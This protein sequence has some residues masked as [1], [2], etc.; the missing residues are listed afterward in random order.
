MFINHRGSDVK[1]TF[2]TRLY[3][4][5]HSSGL[6]AFFDK[7][8][9]QVGYE[10]LSQI[11]AAIKVA[12]VHIAIFSPNYAAS[13]WCLNELVDMKNSGAKII[14][15]FYNVKPSMVRWT[16]KDAVGTYAE[17]L[18]NH[19]EKQRYDRRIIQ[20]WRE[21]LSHAASLS[22]LELEE[23]HG[24]EEE[25]LDK[26]VQSVLKI[27]P[28]P[29][30]DVAKY[31]TGLETKIQ[32]LER[33]VSS[34]EQ[35][36]SP[37]VKVVAIFGLGGLGK[38]TLAAE[39]F[40]RNISVYNRSSFLFDVREHSARGKLNL[41]QSQLIKDLTFKD[42]N[43]ASCAE[44]KGLLERTLSYCHALI[45]LDDVGEVDQLDAFLPI[46]RRVLDPK[47]LI[48]VTSRNLCALTNARIS[49][50]S[51]YK[52]SPLNSP[53]SKELFCK[54][55]F[56]E[57]HPPEGF[58]ELVDGFVAAS[59]GL[60]LSL[61]VFGA[62]VCGQDKPYWDEQ[63]R[64]LHKLPKEIALSLKISYDSLDDDEQQIFLDIACFSLGE[65][66]DKWIRIWGGSG[67]KGLV[68]F[69]NLQNR[70][71]VEVGSE[72]QIRMHDH[73]RDL[74]K[75]I[76]QE[77]N[78]RRLWGATTQNIND[79]LE[80]SY[81]EPPQVRG[82]RMAPRS[83]L[84]DTCNDPL[85]SSERRSSDRL[86]GINKLQLLEAEGDF[87]E[88]ILTWLR[89]PNLIWLSWNKC[90]F[91]SLPPSLPVRDLRVLEVNG[92]E[93][94]E[95][96]QPQS[97]VPMQLRELNVSAP[98]LR[99]PNSLG[100]LKQLEKLVAE[101]TNLGTLPKEFCYLACL[102]YLKL[103]DYKMQILPNSAGKKV[104]NL[105]IGQGRGMQNLPDSMGNL[106]NLQLSDLRQCKSL[107]MLLT[108]AA[109][110]RSQI[111]SGN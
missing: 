39:F 84:T 13:D 65:D 33:M 75:S 95:L 93:L 82:I 38:T 97:Q 49:E 7:P 52:P 61:K 37:E 88:S 44:G 36:E 24:D 43:I 3:S 18:R 6:Q 92:S 54:Y 30:L 1:N 25:L 45:V 102:K 83:T 29:P 101:E 76:A 21:A 74:G 81:P 109:W 89:C 59:G 16:G 41:L 5:L 17:C 69:R 51:I 19:E 67:W 4:S 58:G 100:Q 35:N 77:S 28:K 15:V 22:G 98:L 64:G 46:L 91:S 85:F 55:A 10:I 42:V 71:L 107:E 99:F 34:K 9:M 62:M 70:C 94:Q 27:I 20:K 53:H 66:R 72:N 48:L 32:D 86:L 63:L 47:S 26:L 104:T 11:K 73:L 2:A 79:L 111:P 78:P 87:V 90:P 57:A 23:F 31:P 60:P 108:S 105:Q 8:E 40:N 96:W 80:Q 56:F 12:K 50:T 103:K 14:P 106:T 68:G 110:R